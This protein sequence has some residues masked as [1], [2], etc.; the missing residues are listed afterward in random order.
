MQ[1]GVILL[2]LAMCL[3]PGVDVLAKQLTAE[4]TAFQ[5]AFMR[6]FA[7]GLVALS[8][9]RFLN[10]PIQIPKEARAGQ[11][12]RTALLVASMTCLIAAFSMVPMAYAV[13]GFLI[14]PIVST[15]ICVLFYGEKLTPSRSLGAILSLAGAVLIAKPAAGLELG[16]VLAL[17]GGALLGTYL[18]LTR[19]AKNTGGALNTLAVQCFLGS[20]LVAPLALMGGMP[21]LSWSLIFSVLGLG[22]FSAGAH[23]LTVAAFEKADASI[24]SP[25]LYFN[26]VAAIIVGFFFFN[27]VP[28]MA[29]M[30][31][32]IAIV[33]GGL[34]AMSPQFLPY[35]GRARVRP[36]IL[37]AA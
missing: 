26:L 22:V 29:A 14:S 25:F 35:L 24:L 10:Q 16:T 18:A 33:G 4:H 9:A 30:L 2:I 28:N 8:V 1:S 34:V 19:G 37:A 31:G 5:V 12:F 3:T 20:A 36:A 6:Y 32:L 7:G 23:F 17:F 21:V 13:G 15:L 27:E 11:V